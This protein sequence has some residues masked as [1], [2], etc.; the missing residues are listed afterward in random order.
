[1][2]IV[3]GLDHHG[4]VTD[5]MVRSVNAIV[6]HRTQP[7]DPST[8]VSSERR[9]SSAWFAR[10]WK[11]VTVWR[12]IPLVSHQEQFLTKQAPMKTWFD[13]A[14]HGTGPRVLQACPFPMQPWLDVDDGGWA[15]T[16]T[17]N[18]D[19]ALADSLADELADLC[20]SLRD[21]FQV[22]EAVSVDDA[23]RMGDAEPRGVVVLSDTGD[24]VFGGSAG[25]SNVILEAV[26]RLK[27]AGKVLIPLIG[28][29]AVA[30]MIAAGEG[31][32]VTLPL[33]AEIATRFFQPIVVSG[34]V[35]RIGGGIIRATDNHQSEF[36]M[37]RSVVFEAGSAIVLAS[38]LRGMGGNLPD[39][40]R[41]FGIEPGGTRWRCSR[42]PTSSTSRR[43]AR[44]DTCGPSQSD[45]F[46]LP[47]TR[48][49]DR[50]IT[51]GSPTE[52]FAVRNPSLTDILRDTLRDTRR[53]TM[54]LKRSSLLRA[55]WAAAVMAAA[56]P[57]LPQMAGAQGARIRV[58]ILDDIANYDPHQFSFVNAVLIKNLYDSLLEYTPDGRF[59]E[60]AAAFSRS[61]DRREVGK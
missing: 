31:A 3:L 35:R 61:P 41:A 2:P 50:S 13:R 49:P 58:G 6:A 47:W 8:P 21:A 5:L 10:S 36:D 32:T 34:T 43:S 18:G 15:V 30:Q 37:G 19:R 26:L 40:Y 11:P 29:K 51:R 4:N 55:A 46:T 44:F 22:R 25:D 9:C 60:L 48:T 39:I 59:S 42:Q 45:V 23:V 17:T 56:I 27:P 7:H 12:K 57:L 28:P 33:G 20:W 52:A 54:T 38:E 14:R 24:T 16:V 1:V 53:V